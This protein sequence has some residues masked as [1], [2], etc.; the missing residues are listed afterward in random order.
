MFADHKVL[1]QGV[2]VSELGQIRFLCDGLDKSDRFTSQHYGWIGVRTNGRTNKWLK[3]LEM[4]TR[5]DECQI[6]N[7]VGY[8]SEQSSSQVKHHN[9]VVRL[10][11][12]RLN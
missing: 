12:I 6:K 10:S 11:T 4:D 2:V 8:L 5:T 1:V 3:W 7:V 9:N